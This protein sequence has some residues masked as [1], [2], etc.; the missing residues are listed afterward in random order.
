MEKL[1]TKIGKYHLS[2]NKMKKELKRNINSSKQYSKNN[3][4]NKEASMAMMNT[5]YCDMADK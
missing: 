4:H 5:L 3:K 1:Y 2:K